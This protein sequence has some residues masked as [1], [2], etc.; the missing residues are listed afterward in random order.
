MGGKPVGLTMHAA[1]HGPTMPATQSPWQAYCHDLIIGIAASILF[2]S[3]Y[4]NSNS[5]PSTKSKS[6]N[7]ICENRHTNTVQVG[8]PSRDQP[9]RQDS[10]HSSINFLYPK[11]SQCSQTNCV[12][13]NAQTNH[14]SMVG[15]QRRL[16]TPVLTKSPFPVGSRRRLPTPN[17]HSSLQTSLSPKP[18]TLIVRTQTPPTAP[19]GSISI[20]VS[21]I[22]TL[23][24]TVRVFAPST[25]GPSGPRGST[26][27]GGTRY[28]RKHPPTRLRRFRKE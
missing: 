3:P 19:E 18:A 5:P 10:A 22:L 13:S 15:S 24:V 1:G 25:L 20:L 21:H 14:H 16:P 26:A 6:P 27:P 28:R 2:H 9:N 7:T 8:K 12:G 11:S 4:M 17:H 23:S